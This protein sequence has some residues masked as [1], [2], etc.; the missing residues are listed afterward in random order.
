MNLIFI[1]I[2]QLRGE[3]GDIRESVVILLD[4]YEKICFVVYFF[5]C[6]IGCCKI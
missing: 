2:N 4:F 6:L 5:L 3:N 1:S